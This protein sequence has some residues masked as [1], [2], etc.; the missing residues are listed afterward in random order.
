MAAF[1]GP[2]RADGHRSGLETSN[3]AFL[4]KHGVA[5]DYESHRI[6]YVVP[7]RRASYTPDFVLANGIIIETK[8][9]F[10]A[11]DRQ[12]HLLIKQ[13]HP[14]LDI[15]FVFSRSSTTLTKV[16]KIVDGQKLRREN[17]TTYATWCAKHGFLFADKTPP[18]EWLA[19]PSCPER[20]AALEAAAEKMEFEP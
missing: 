1:K 14:G 10:D 7:R 3:A 17:P 4:Q 13:Q 5:Y 6:H 16:M 18:L 19:E 2:L 11:E 12:K 9:I 8:G 20:L 15:R